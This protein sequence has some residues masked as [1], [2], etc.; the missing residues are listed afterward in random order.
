MGKSTES[1]KTINKNNLLKDSETEYKSIEALNNVQDIKK[2]IM[3]K[4]KVAGEIIQN[5]LNNIRNNKVNNISF[6]DSEISEIYKEFQNRNHLIKGKKCLVFSAEFLIFN[7]CDRSIKDGNDFINK[8]IDKLDKTFK[9][10]G[11][12]DVWL[13]A[14]IVADPKRY[15]GMIT[16]DDE[17]I[18]K[19]VYKLW[20]DDYND[21]LVLSYCYIIE[22]KRVVPLNNVQKI[23]M[24]KVKVAGEIIQSELNNIRNNKVNNISFKDSEIS[25]ICKEFQN[26][27]HLTK[28]KK[29][30]VFCVEFLIFNKS[31]RSIK[32]GNDFINKTI[33]KLNKI[34]KEKGFTSSWIAADLVTNSAYISDEM[35]EFIDKHVYKLWTDDYNDRLV[36]SYCHIIN[37]ESWKSK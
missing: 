31:D 5:E 32:D 28:R 14:N 4:V 37:V 24:G 13:A 36:L 1:G 10:K 21:R 3:G 33:D 6:K 16:A 30:L 29:Y 22:D 11:F 2:I 12:T 35:D 18:D 7:K 34:F 17:F 19:H 23:V 15:I 9:E 20:T 25:E 27:S 26:S 8:T